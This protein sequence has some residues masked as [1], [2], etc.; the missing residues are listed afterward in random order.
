MRLQELATALKDAERE[1][2]R[3]RLALKQIAYWADSVEA[4][5]CP[6][7]RGIARKALQEPAQGAEAGE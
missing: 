3:L 1:N 2:E 5:D 4:E 6:T 7:L